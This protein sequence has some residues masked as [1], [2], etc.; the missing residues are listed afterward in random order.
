MDILRKL[1]HMSMGLFA[2]ALRWLSPWQAMLCALLAFLHNLYIFPLYGRKKLEKDEEK[3]RGY[4]AIV[5]YPAVVFVIIG[6]ATVLSWPDKIAA[7]AIA[8]AAWGILAF[9]DAFGAII[10]QSLKGPKLPWNREKTISGL[11]SFIVL[12]A[13]AGIFLFSFVFSYTTSDIFKDSRIWFF[14]IGS[15]ILGSIIESLPEQFDDNIGFPIVAVSF[16]SFFIVPSLPYSILYF[17]YFH[18]HPSAT[19]VAVLINLGLALIAFLRKW[20]D[21]WGFIFGFLVGL[22]VIFALGTIGFAILCLFYF[23]AN[24][25]TFYGKK[26][27]EKRGIAEGNKGTRGLESIFSKGLA[28]AIYAWFSFPAFVV[29]LAFYAADTV[30][31]EFG[32]TSR[33]GTFSLLSFKSVAPGSVGAVSIKGTIFGVLCIMF[34]LLIFICDTNQYF[35]YSLLTFGFFILESIINEINS[36]YQLTSKTVIHLTL[37]FLIGACASSLFESFWRILGF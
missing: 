35:A 19:I 31:T 9:G 18:W 14:V 32:K 4:T 25:S 29:T 11:L 20:V 12:G 23:L 2:L 17:D 34:V 3:K 5:S 27:K 24:F 6:L 26:I 30:A 37:G 8:A 1:I 15:S 7:M 22:S 36:K 16:L 10:G 21:I 33:K 28:P 13:L